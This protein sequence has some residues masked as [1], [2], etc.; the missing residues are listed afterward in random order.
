MN[1]ITINKYSYY[2]AVGL[3]DLEIQGSRVQTWL[4]S[5]DFFQDVIILSTSTP[6]GTL[7]WGSRV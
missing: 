7:S 4:R 2:E 6:R 3:G 1:V 5:M